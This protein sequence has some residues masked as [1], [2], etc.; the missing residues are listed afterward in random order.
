MIEKFEIIKYKCFNDFTLEGL[1]RINVIS[2][3]N[4]VGK[5][6]LLEAFYLPVNLLGEYGHAG[7]F[8]I[9]SLMNIIQ[10]RGTSN[11]TLKHNLSS[12]HY[13]VIINDV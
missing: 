2:G 4:N 8:I 3:K 10:N 6:A 1:S 13:D 7:E 12:I 5:T 11:K 9:H